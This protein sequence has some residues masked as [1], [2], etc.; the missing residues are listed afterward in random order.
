MMVLESMPAMLESINIPIIPGRNLE[1]TLMVK[2]PV[3]ILV[4]RYR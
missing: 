3:I 4:V 1:R 2:Q